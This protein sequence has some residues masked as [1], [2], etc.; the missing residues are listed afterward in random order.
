MYARKFSAHCSNVKI[1]GGGIID[2]GGQRWWEVW[3]AKQAGD[4]DAARFLSKDR[5]K[6]HARRS[7]AL[8]AVR[9]LMRNDCDNGSLDHADVFGYLNTWPSQWC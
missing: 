8:L 1:D 5:C 9:C 3:A 2:G 6:P 4:S 7:A